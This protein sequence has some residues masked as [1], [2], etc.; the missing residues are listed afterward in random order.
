MALP[1]V[2]LD[3]SSAQ[4]GTLI[5]H[6]LPYLRVVLREPTLA[7]VC[8]ARDPTP[9]LSGPGRLTALGHESFALRRPYAREAARA[10]P[11]HPLLRGRPG[12][13]CVASGAGRLDVRACPR[14]G[15][16]RR[17]GAVLA[18]GVRWALVRRGRLGLGWAAA[19]RLLRR[20]ADRRVATRGASA[21]RPV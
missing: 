21:Y 16:D 6:G 7:G 14:A 20:V 19:V 15:P 5:R 8:G 17:R 9:L 18:S 11:L 13:G 1:D 4:E 3:S 2:P 12:H 10:D